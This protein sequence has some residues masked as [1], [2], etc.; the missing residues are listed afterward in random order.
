MFWRLSSWQAPFPIPPRFYPPLWG[1]R[2]GLIGLL[3]LPIFGFGCVQL[4][5]ETNPYVHQ[6]LTSM[7][8]CVQIGGVRAP[9]PVGEL[10][11]VEMTQALSLAEAAWRAI[12]PDML[13][14]G[15]PFW[16]SGM[17]PFTYTFPA[18]SL[19]RPSAV[20]RMSP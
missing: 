5:W 2:I 20:W 9:S 12:G 6:R 1:F 11:N 13:L 17:L 7:W 18:M 4:M 8:G 14:S 19:L 3:W 15:A 10:G 16:P